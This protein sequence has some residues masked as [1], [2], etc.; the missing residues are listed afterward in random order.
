MAGLRLMEAAK[1]L[2]RAGMQFDEIKCRLRLDAC[3]LSKLLE[4]RGGVPAGAVVSDYSDLYADPE[5]LVE[6][7]GHDP[8]ALLKSSLEIEAVARRLGMSLPNAMAARR[9]ERMGKIQPSGPWEEKFYPEAGRVSSGKGFSPFP[10]VFTREG[11]GELEE[12]ADALLADMA[13][14]GFHGG[15]LKRFSKVVSKLAAAMP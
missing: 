13:E 6:R 15:R 8:N 11:G 9:R 10:R 14:A 12:E 3:V 4:H 2:A 7:E 5:S 1:V